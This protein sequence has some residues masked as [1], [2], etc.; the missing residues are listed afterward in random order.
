MAQLGPQAVFAAFHS[1]EHGR[2]GGMVDRFVAVVGQQVLLGDV[3]D[4]GA[5]LAL[6]EQMIERLLLERADVL[7][8]RQPPLLGFAELRVDVE[9]DSPERKGPVADHLADAEFCDTSVHVGHDAPP[10]LTAT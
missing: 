3:G 8:D 7:V 6:G 9:D 5:V 4:V 10:R 2:D 1:V